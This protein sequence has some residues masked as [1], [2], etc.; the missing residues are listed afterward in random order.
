MAHAFRHDEALSRRKVDDSIFEIDQE[1]PIE[2]EE[3]FIDV[4]VFVPVILALNDRH[5]HH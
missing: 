4:F 5:S 1:L 2:H 3:K